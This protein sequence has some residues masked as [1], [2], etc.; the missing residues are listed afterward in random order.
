MLTFYDFEMNPS[1][2]DG[3]NTLAI[4]LG[5]YEKGD[6]YLTPEEFHKI[7]YTFEEG[8]LDVVCFYYAD[9]TVYHFVKWLSKAYPTL[10]IA[11]ASD[12]EPEEKISNFLTYWIDTTYIQDVQVFKIN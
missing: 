12:L 5:Y 10:S 3:E 6:P 1:L 9:A 4:K 11:I 2:I 8:F 7:M